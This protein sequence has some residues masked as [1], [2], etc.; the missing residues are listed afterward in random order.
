MRPPAAESSAEA[1]LNWWAQGRVMGSPAEILFARSCS[2]ALDAP[3]AGENRPASDPVTDLNVH[4]QTANCRRATT[5]RE[6]W[7]G[8]V[9]VM[10]FSAFNP[11]APL[12]E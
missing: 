11:P 4:R 9:V 5:S 12:P 3:G 8:G 6:D 7:P 1:C 2:V 10:A